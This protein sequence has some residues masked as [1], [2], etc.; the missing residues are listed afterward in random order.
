MLRG[1]VLE[2]L[3][4]RGMLSELSLRRHGTFR[5][6]TASRTYRL[7]CRNG[8]RRPKQV[9][10]SRKLKSYRWVLVT[11]E[12]KCSIADA[13]QPEIPPQ[14]H[15]VKDGEPVRVL[16]AFV[17]N[18]INQVNIWTP[19]L[20]RA[21]SA[22]TRWEKTRPTLEG[23]RL[24]VGMVVGGYTQYLT[25]VQGMP[26]GVETLFTKK[27]CHFMYGSDKVP[28][29]GLPVL[30]E[31]IGDGG[32]KV[33]DVAVR[34]HAI[35]LMKVKSY[36]TL[37]ASRPK[38]ESKFVGKNSMLPAYLCHMLKTAKLFNVSLNPVALEA[39]LKRQM[40]IWYHLGLNGDRV[41]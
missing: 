23:K 4:V 15:I 38:W 35:E 25:R 29:V 16:G 32:R 26:K 20:E 21:E 13:G 3:R 33:L 7:S 9:S 18:G 37:D 24:V 12:Q 31:N 36:Q 27:I 30:H 6:T 28:L 39:N 10:M 34:N 8:A 2:G 14:I 22:L 41:L 17:G 19:I 11:I 5:K 1:S 40:P